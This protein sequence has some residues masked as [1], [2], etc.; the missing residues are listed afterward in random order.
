M[1]MPKSSLTGGPESAA[2]STRPIIPNEIFLEIFGYI[3]ASVEIEPAE[4]RHILS[5]LSLVCTFFWTAL[6]PRLFEWLILS[7]YSHRSAAF[8]QALIHGDVHALALTVHI[9]ACVILH[10]SAKDSDPGVAAASAEMYH[11]VLRWAPNVEHLQIYGL[12]IDT[13]FWRA[14]AGLSKLR[15]LILRFGS[16]RGDI[17]P[18]EIDRVAGLRVSSLNIW[19]SQLFCFNP[20]T[21]SE[22]CCSPNFLNTLLASGPIDT[23]ETL[24]ISPCRDDMWSLNILSKVPSVRNLTIDPSAGVVPQSDF[25]SLLPNLCSL[26]SSMFGANTT[27]HWIWALF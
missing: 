7:E 3:Q 5:Q 1:T 27:P 18:E 16:F 4:R 24:I 19:R 6:R 2:A 11:Q 25:P 13:G 23:L 10:P 9:R 14:I 20:A 8:C 21:L 22:L 15:T 12:N 17:P 26:T